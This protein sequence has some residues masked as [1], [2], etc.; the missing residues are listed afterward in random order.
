MHCS[1]MVMKLLDSLQATHGNNCI[2]L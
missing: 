1:A 2:G